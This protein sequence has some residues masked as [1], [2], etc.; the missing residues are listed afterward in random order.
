MGK[1]PQR[2]SMIRLSIRPPKA[3]AA[4]GW[5]RGLRETKTFN[6][7][8]ACGNPE[9]RGPQSK[10]EKP[11][12]AGNPIPWASLKDSQREPGWQI[13]TEGLVQSKNKPKKSQRVRTSMNIPVKKLL[14]LI[15][16]VCTISWTLVHFTVTSH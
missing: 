5:H 4:E 11:K 15:Q 10:P 12:K 6:I 9:S 13:P 7:G 3:R 16:P 8:E 1:E 14:E 2:A